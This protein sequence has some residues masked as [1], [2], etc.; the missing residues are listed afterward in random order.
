MDKFS[1]PGPADGSGFRASAPGKSSSSTPT[2]K[3]SGSTKLG[4][5]SPSLVPEVRDGVGFSAA[6]SAAASLSADAKEAAKTASRAVQ[7]QASQF[8]ADVGHELKKTAEDQKMRGVEAIQCFARAIGSAAGE[9]DSQSPRIAQSVRD[10]A[11]KVDG[12]SHNI[13]G[14]N[15]DELMNAA[16]EL[17]RSQPML[18]IGGAIAAGFALSRF[19]KS[20]ASSHV[21]TSRVSPQDH[22]DHMA[23]G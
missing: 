19:L 2:G 23:Q 12:L 16:T 21:S 14:R 20:S 6:S 18:F 11:Q 3:P 10:A 1:Q 5:A 8:A 4:T 15:V 13:S 7:E 9:L 17:A 22:P